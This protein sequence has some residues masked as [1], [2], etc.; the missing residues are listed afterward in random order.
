[1]KL[2]DY[3]HW[4]GSGQANAFLR[5]SSNL[6]GFYHVCF[7][8]R[9][10]QLGLLKILASKPL[11]QEELLIALHLA[12]ETHSTGLKAFLHLGL[13]L[14]AIGLSRDRYTL[15]GKLAKAMADP[16]F[17]A[18]LS[19][20]EEASGL[21]APYIAAALSEEMAVEKLKA[22]SDRHAEVIARSSK[23]AEPVLKSVLDSLIPVSGPFSFLEIGSGSGVYLLH[24][25]SRNPRLTAIG[26]ELVEDLAQRIT[27]KI[28]DAGHA[29]RARMLAC[30]MWT[31]DYAA[32]FDC[33]TLFNNIYYFP[34]S[35]QPKLLEKLYRW[36]KPGGRL[37]IATLCRGGKYPIDAI[38]H[39]WSA[40]TPGASILPEPQAFTKRMADSGFT[41]KAVT[42]SVLDGAMK[43]FVGQK[44]V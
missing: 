18:F 32:C 23:I 14:G 11:T 24:A 36:L 31:L 38:M 41:A 42:P 16:A 13:T 3:V 20:A 29:D 1:M 9:A 35:E 27:E 15:K 6:K 5:L 2:N 12:P 8:A 4:I 39:M 25:L 26:V 21:H 37:A 34:E 22:C 7:L 17:D 40:M 30:D 33:I 43:V 44:P 28:L 10:G 19:M